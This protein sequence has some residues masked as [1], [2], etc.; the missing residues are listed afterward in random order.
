MMN[1]KNIFTLDEIFDPYIP[2]NLKNVTNY[3]SIYIT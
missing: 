2:I 1:K 3:Y